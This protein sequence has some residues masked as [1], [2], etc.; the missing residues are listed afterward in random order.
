MKK[1]FSF[2]WFLS[3]SLVNLLADD[4]IVLKNGDV[5]SGTVI[6]VS[7]DAIK[8]K[9]SSNPNGPTYTTNRV[10]VLSIKYS[11][12]EV[13]KFGKTSNENQTNHDSQDS[14]I[15]PLNPNKANSELIRQYNEQYPTRHGKSPKNKIVVDGIAYWGFTDESILSTDDFEVRFK[16]Q[17]GTE[18]ET[19]SYSLFNEE[20]NIIISIFNKTKDVI[21]ID[22]ANTFK[23]DRYNGENKGTT[24]Y[25]STVIGTNNSSGGG[26]TLG[27]GAVSSALG[28]GGIVGTLASGIGIGGGNS[29]STNVTTQMERII[30]I[31]PM[32]EV[33][34]PPH[35]YVVDKKIYSDYEIFRIDRLK[36]KD[37]LAMRKYEL[38]KYT[39]DETLFKRDYYITFSKTPTFNTYCTIPIYLYVRAIYGCSG[40]EDVKVE[41][42][43]IE[44]PS[45]LLLSHIYVWK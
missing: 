18:K 14:R 12:G 41:N 1:I 5:L 26:A 30:A 38:K 9:K 3:L 28:I 34:L 8:Y 31:P 36:L 23:V 17:G 29:S 15:I 13:E 19:L 10:E 11:N 40:F 42:Y 2:L 22:L 45:R 44:N 32:S 25:D 20:N 43:N 21:Y 7:S 6:E 35:K 37:K 33:P 24:W 39:Y 4:V 16:R 27:L